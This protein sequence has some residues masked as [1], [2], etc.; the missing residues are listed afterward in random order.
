MIWTRRLG[1][2]RSS[3]HRCS[4]EIAEW[5]SP[6]ASSSRAQPTRQNA[7]DAGLGNEKVPHGSCCDCVLLAAAV[8][9]G[10]DAISFDYCLNV[11]Q[12]RWLMTCTH[13][14]TLETGNEEKASAKWR[15]FGEMDAVKAILIRNG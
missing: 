15:N 6:E 4:K 12:K 13:G 10:P 9:A 5:G 11:L 3:D 8:G 14:E 1:F 2:T 7:L